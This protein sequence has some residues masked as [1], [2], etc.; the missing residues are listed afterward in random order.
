MNSINLTSSGVGTFPIMAASMSHKL[1]N[2]YFS[3]LYSNEHLNPELLLYKNIN[4]WKINVINPDKYWV[5][6]KISHNNIHDG[7]I[8]DK[9]VKI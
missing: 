3:N 8:S 9:F 7:A 1:K 6:D 2:F 5:I 4:L